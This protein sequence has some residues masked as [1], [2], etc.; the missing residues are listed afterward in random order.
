MR[1][2]MQVC[3]NGHVINDRFFNSPEYNKEFCNRCGK[4]T[5]T[6]CPNPRC[7]KPIPGRL[8]GSVYVGRSSAPDFCQHCGEKFPWTR[9]E[10]VKRLKEEAEKPIEALQRIFSKFHSIARKL[11]GRYDNRA[12]FDVNDEYDVQDLL[13][14]LLVLCFDDIRPEE[15]TPSY[16]GQSARMDFLLKK[17]KIVVETKMTRKG[18]ADKEIG[19]QLIVDIER[20]K[21]HPD[22]DTLICFVYDPGGRI[23]N[24]R[25]LSGDLEKQSRE[26]L[27][28]MVFV[29]PS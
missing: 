26:N 11:R 22:C 28:V 2:T 27:K 7:D 3:L 13:S 18:L 10:E 15:W 24:P 4:Q 19:N 14:A 29:E 16:A 6:N 1:D 25:G 23:A 20:Y 9:K 12:T 17:E 8:L 21:E 5:V